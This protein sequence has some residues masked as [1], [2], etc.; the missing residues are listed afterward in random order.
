MHRYIHGYIATCK[1]C[2]SL[3]I[4]T[5][6]SKHLDECG[7]GIIGD[8]VYVFFSRIALSLVSPYRRVYQVRSFGAPTVYLVGVS[9]RC[10]AIV[11]VSTRQV[12][13]GRG[14]KSELPSPSA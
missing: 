1:Q 10:L 14:M 7:D 2:L 3:W 12:W 5:L 11:G 4:L 8:D 6:L 9:A 13:H